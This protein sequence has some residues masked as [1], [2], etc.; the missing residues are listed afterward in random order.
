MNILLGHSLDKGSFR[1]IKSSAAI[2]GDATFGPAGMIGILETFLGLPCQRHSEILR[3][4]QYE[5][6]LRAIDNNSRF[7]SASF[8]LDPRGAASKILFLRDEILLSAPP[9]FSLS[10]LGKMSDRIR[11]IAEV[12]IHATDLVPGYPDRLRAIAKE[13][14][15]NRIPIPIGRVTL[16]EPI[17]TW[18][19][20]WQALFAAMK[21]HGCTFENFNDPTTVSNGDLSI[22]KRALTHQGK[23]VA[24]H[25][26]ASLL[27]FEANNPVEEADVVALLARELSKDGESVVL[28]AGQETNVLNDAFRRIN[29]PLPGGSLQSFGLD[30]LQILPLCFALSWR[31][32]DPRILQQYLSLSVSPV[33]RKLRRQLLE[34]VS[35]T[36]STGGPQ[37][38]EIIAEYIDSLENEKQDEA[39][40][41]IERWL[42]IGRIGP[43]DQIVT[44]DIDTLC[45]TFEA[46]ARKRAFL[47]ETP[48][49]GMTMA[50]EQARAISDACKILGNAAVGRQELKSL[51]RDIVATMPADMNARRERGSVYTVESPGA[52]LGPVDNVIWWN[53]GERSLEPLPTKFWTRAEESELK[54]KG[55]VLPEATSSLARQRCEW[56]RGISFARNRLL[57]AYSRTHGDQR[58]PDE[59]H[60]LWHELTAQFDKDTIGNLVVFAADA[61]HGKTNSFIEKHIKS[62]LSTADL[63]SLPAFRAEW[64]LKHSLIKDRDHHSAS[65]ITRLGGCAFSYVCNYLAG[66]ESAKTSAVS[67]KELLYG[68]VAHDVIER[69]LAAC[70][71]WPEK[72]NIGKNVRTIFQHYLEKEGAVLNLPGMD[73]ER[74]YL[75]KRIILS[76][77]QLVAM[78]SAGRYELL[79]IEK[80]FSADTEIGPMKG[81]CDL[82]FKKAGQSRG[83]AVIDL[84]WGGRDRR[85]QELSEG[86]SIQLA[87]YSELLGQPFPATG[88][89]II[90]TGELLTVHKEAFAGA[91]IIDGPN[92]R[93]TWKNVVEMVGLRRNALSSG[94]AVMGTPDDNNVEPDFMYAQCRYCELDLFCRTQERV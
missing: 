93:A 1:P 23:I 16:T 26:D 62:H 37:W 80:E 10:D 35:R 61:L 64:T 53:A 19:C 42:S 74:I 47:Q 71:G 82:V 66:I 34:I 65:S 86:K 69:F 14:N 94:K 29:G 77:E 28:I 70:D 15:G 67:E 30:A 11:A 44:T 89:F 52:I 24:A 8:R 43:D 17:D 90:S 72:R 75:E 78:L 59:V 54:E 73:K 41:T 22:A 81:F 2:A 31:P 32:A 88:Y 76:C 56:E 9:D 60:P 27:L 46:W 57:F 79:G 40:K 55:I 6:A 7:F 58:Q 49:L 33:P 3:V 18:P 91:T 84:K 20:L 36:G 38:A 87:I 85:R 63:R 5:T 48:E 68:N 25:G 21:T 50:I 39:K 51:V 45:K 4:I 12:E 92:E 13:L 83:R